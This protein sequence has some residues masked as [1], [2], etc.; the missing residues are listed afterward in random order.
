M[1]IQKT[2]TFYRLKSETIDDFDK[3]IN[4]FLNVNNVYIIDFKIN[5]GI[6]DVIGACRSFKIYYDYINKEERN[7]E[8]RT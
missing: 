7:N 6:S 5:E 1:L 3:R 8:Q 4:E 2:K